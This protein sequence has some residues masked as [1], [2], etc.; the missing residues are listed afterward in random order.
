MAVTI[1]I[2]RLLLCATCEV[3]FEMSTGPQRSP[4]CPGCGSELAVWP[5][6]RWVNRKGIAMAGASATEARELIAALD[7]VSAV[8]TAR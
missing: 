2:G 1:P 7:R 5:L 4:A 6:W 3:A 8:R